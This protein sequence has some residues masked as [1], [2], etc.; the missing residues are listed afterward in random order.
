MASGWRGRTRPSVEESPPARAIRGARVLASLASLV[1]LVGPIARAAPDCLALKSR[2]DQL[3]T[4]AMTAEI[5]LLHSVRKRLCPR[6]EAQAMQA[7]RGDTPAGA[8][9]PFD[10]EGYIRCRQQAEAHL[11]QTRAVLY[12]NLRRFPFYTAEGA[13]LARDA[14][15]VQRQLQAPCPAFAR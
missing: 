1:M 3:A 5:T 6:Q 14:D 13:R 11:Q 12:R 10:Y 9:A 7:L 4:Q 8:V 15:G 2:R